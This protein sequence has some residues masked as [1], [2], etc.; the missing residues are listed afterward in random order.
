MKNE[1]INGIKEAFI[2]ITVAL[3]TAFIV[4]SPSIHF[5]LLEYDFG[6]VAE[7]T[8]QNTNSCF[9]TGVQGPSALRK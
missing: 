1:I 3:S 7:N 4:P 6:K 5:D 2:A 8:V 9:T